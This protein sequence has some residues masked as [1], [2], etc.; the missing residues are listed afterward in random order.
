VNCR[1]RKR[2]NISCLQFE[3]NAEQN[4]MDLT[5]ELNQRRYHPRPSFCFITKNDKYR[6]VFAADFRDRIVHHYLVNYLEKIWEPVF[7]YD[8]Y[9]CRKG[10][11]T[12]SA[13]KRLQAFMRKVTANHTRRAWF[14]QLDIKAFFPSIDRRVLLS[15]VL[16]RLEDNDLRWLAK[17]LIL[18]DPTENPIFTCSKNN[19]K[20]VPPHKSLFSVANDKGLPIGNLTSQFFANVYLNKLD[21]FIKHQLKAPY[22]IRFVDDFVLVH[23]NRTMLEQWK[24]QIESL[25]NHHLA[26]EL[27]PNRQIIRPVSNG[28]NFLGYVVKPKYI[29]VRRKIAENC[30]HMVQK[31]TNPMIKYHSNVIVL[32]FPY[33]AYFDLYRRLN[34]YLGIFSHASCHRFVHR[35]F[36]QFWVLG[37][38]FTYCAN[39]A[40][41]N[42]ILDFKPANLYTQYRF[43]KNR[44]PGLV[45]FQVG[46][47]CEFFDKDAKMVLNKFNLHEVKPYKGFYCRCGFNTNAF[48]GY[49]N[50]NI[51]VPVLL[52]TQTEDLGG[53]VRKR[54]GSRLQ[55]PKTE[56][57]WNLPCH[58]PF[59]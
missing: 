3:I 6:E 25:L 15:M 13:V 27:N 19:W 5:D 14:A 55:F 39:Q 24:E 31:C 29:L 8:S 28:V 42:W 46:C 57:R 20:R 21:Q 41:M 38:L 33:D 2:N 10:K 43:F 58:Q 32:D 40:K 7:I 56:F 59:I 1:R 47:Y 18:N 9:A 26:L 49:I 34:S 35:L 36:S 52:V 54:S 11:G 16:S 4:L 37:V 51:N 22:Y 23:Q 53:S 50:N 48:Y 12:H 30:K 44:F 17:T 45:V